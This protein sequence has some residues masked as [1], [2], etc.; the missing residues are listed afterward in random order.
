MHEQLDVY[1]LKKEVRYSI[2]FVKEG[3]ANLTTHSTQ[4]IYGYTASDILW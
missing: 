3:N 4:F 2:C 1:Y